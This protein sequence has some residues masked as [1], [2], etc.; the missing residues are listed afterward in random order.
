M[1]IILNR[2]TTFHQA[3]KH[4]KGAIIGSSFIQ[5]IASNPISRIATFIQ[6]LL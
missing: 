3:T 2:K 5:F 4:Q 6:N 1:K